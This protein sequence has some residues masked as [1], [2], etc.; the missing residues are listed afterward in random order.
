ML[1]IIVFFGLAIGL[2]QLVKAT[3]IVEVVDWGRLTF[4]K[5]ETARGWFFM[6]ICTLTQSDVKLTWERHQIQDWISL[7]NGL[8]PHFEWSE[9]LPLI[10]QT[11]RFHGFRWVSMANIRSQFQLE[12]RD[13]G[14]LN[15]SF[16]TRS[17]GTA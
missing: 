9:F 3:N 15:G 1:Q 2:G 11:S 4:M 8:T 17:I 7:P 16:Q 13:L 6:G 5:P 14:R 12:I 10:F